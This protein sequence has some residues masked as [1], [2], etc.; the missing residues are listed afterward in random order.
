VN[1][2]VSW[3]ALQ[4]DPLVVADAGPLIS[5]GRLDL[6]SVLARLFG[7]VHVPTAVVDE[8]LARP[9]QADAQR[10]R[11]ALDAG[12]LISAEARPIQA[13]ELDAGECAAIGLA[14]ELHA[15]L[16]TDDQAARRYAIHIDLPVMGTLGLLILAKRRGEVAEVGRLIQQLRSSGQ[17]FSEDVVAQVLRAAGEGAR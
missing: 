16:L 14:L 17:R 7:V 2:T 1:W 12:W 8:C 9:E 6:L 3:P 10:I 5:L 13:P 11:A 15:R 4:T